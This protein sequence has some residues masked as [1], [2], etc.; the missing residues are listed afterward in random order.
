MRRRG[1]LIALAAIALGLGVAGKVILGSRS[2]GPASPTAAGPPAALPAP[3]RSPAELAEAEQVMAAAALTGRLRLEGQVIDADEAPVEGAIVSLAGTPPLKVTSEADGGFV[4]DGVRAG[5]HLLVASAGELYGGPVRVV[6]GEQSEPVILRLRA[7]TAVEVAVI[8]G[9]SSAPVAGAAVELRGL[10][11]FEGATGADGLAALAGVAPGAYTLVVRAAGLGVHR[12]ELTVPPQAGRLRHQVTLL[13]GH[14]VTGRVRAPDG[15]PIAGALVFAESATGL[16]APRVD[17]LRDGATTGADGEFV[18]DSVPLGSHRFTARHPGWAPGSSAP[19]LV[20]GTTE[21]RVDITLEPGA[22]LAGT[23]VDAG[24]QPVEN[25]LVRVSQA[26]QGGFRPRAWEATADQAGRFTLTGLPRARLRAEARSAL[27]AS[28]PVDVDLRR[29]PHRAEL[30]LRLAVDGVIAGHVVDPA[31]E[32]LAE[33]Q[34]VALPDLGTAASAEGLA[35][36]TAVD[37]TDA[38]GGFRLGGL[39]PGEY[40]LRATRNGSAASRD[41]YGRQG[42]TAKVGQQDVRIVLAADGGV[43]GVV[44]FADGGAP[45]MFL[46]KTGVVAPTPFAGDDGEFALADVAPGVITLT[47][48]G[49][50]FDPTVVRDVTIEPGKVTDVGTITLRKGRTLSG[51]VITSA[52]QPVAGAQVFAGYRVVGDGAE[53]TMQA[54]GPGGSGE[55]KQV[56]SGADGSFTIRGTGF[57]ELALIADHPQAG[58]SRSV[59]VP[60]SR[61]SVS[62][63]LVLEPTGAI[64]G[65]VSRGGQPVEAILVN[66]YPQAMAHSS[67]FVVRSGP[68][69]DYRIDRVTAGDYV[70]TAMAG[71]SPLSGISSQG[72][73]VTVAPGQTARADLTLPETPVTLEV[74]VLRPDRTHVPMAEVMVVGGSFA[75][76]TAKQVHDR[77]AE[78]AGVFYSFNIIYDGRPARVKQLNPGEHTAC[79]IPFPD[80]IERRDV[81][82]IMQYV[83][84][85][86]DTLPAFCVPVMVT[87]QPEQRIAVDVVQPPMPEGV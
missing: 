64:E 80:G 73:P 6:L 37:V 62:V 12:A 15:Q 44:E 30:Q 3:V 25:A 20:D 35:G 16:A 21:R 48:S 38:G 40:Q 39:A 46:V 28:Q 70:V 19:V 77:A 83:D 41:L 10:A 79:A 53:L 71:S 81:A 75:A 84:D 8:D 11:G 36:R 47:I 2:S 78:Q 42:V 76:T 9:R 13:P 60:A 31:G 59:K 22:A 66:A 87:E 1:G 34:V 4:F 32:P 7:G 29:P 54:W 26:G 45:P 61:E 68:A 72:V 74:A 58:R 69:G 24:G 52:G 57:R 14:R 33:V 86:I 67:N 82:V 63:D 55:T 23:V 51:R 5:R 50:S 43:R 85:H 18:L 17:P 27:A 49:P 56:T 65:R